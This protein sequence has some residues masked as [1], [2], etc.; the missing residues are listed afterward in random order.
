MQ[1]VTRFLEARL[2]L[3]VNRA[4]SAVSRS[5]ERHFL[6]FRLRRDSADD[7]VAVMLSK[8]SKERIDEKIRLLTPRSWGQSFADC[9]RRLNAYLR[10]WIGFFRVCTSSS[11]FETLD[12]HIRRRLRAL[13][14]KQWKQKST[15]A[16]RLIHLG[17][18][19]EAAWSTVYAGNRSWWALSHT[20]SVDWALRNRVFGKRYGLVSL[21]KRWK[22][23]RRQV[24]TGPEQ[25]LLLGL[26]AGNR[27]RRSKGGNSPDPARPEEPDVG[28]TS[29]VL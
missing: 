5:G 20:P 13:L 29:P 26:S 14:L 19:R 1:S 24:G 16:K 3:S 18:E 25:Q 22:E 4:K 21:E 15:I 2:R 6:G 11:A 8:R 23:L 17:V 7:S 28:P 10:G 9:I 27:R 12:A